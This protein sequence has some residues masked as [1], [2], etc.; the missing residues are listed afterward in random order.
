MRQIGENLPKM[1]DQR[2]LFVS[3]KLSHNSLSRRWLEKPPIPFFET[4]AS[5]VPPLWHFQANLLL[6]QENVAK[7][8]KKVKAD[9]TPPR[10]LTPLELEHDDDLR[11]PRTPG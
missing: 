1:S 10:S 2:N 9:R 5:A 4:G 7:N 6:A 8:V 11:P 3:Q